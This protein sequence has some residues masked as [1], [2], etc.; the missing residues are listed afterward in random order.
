[1]R[2]AAKWARNSHKAHATTAHTQT[3]GRVCLSRC[4]ARLVSLGLA[5]ARLCAGLCAL[6]C[7][8]LVARPLACS[9]ARQPGDTT[10][11]AQHQWQQL[12]PTLTA[13]PARDSQSAACRNS[14]P[15]QLRQLY[16]NANSPPL[17]LSLPLPGRHSQAQA[18]R[19][20]PQARRLTTRGLRRGPHSQAAR[21]ALLAGRSTARPPPSQQAS[22]PA[23]RQP[24]RPSADATKSRSGRRCSCTS[25]RCC[26]GCCC[27]C[28]CCSAA[29][30]S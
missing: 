4:S 1:V 29:L 6:L 10:A 16:A 3:K 17:C 13:R 30:A 9:L 28:C 11:L 14:P 8:L 21:C 12:H 23:S 22:Q 7:S 20:Q 26:T 24:G 18:R 27:C 19:S 25:C 2:T 15:V 5:F